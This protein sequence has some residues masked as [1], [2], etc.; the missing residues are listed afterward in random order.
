MWRLPQGV[1]SEVKACLS[2]LKKPAAGPRP[3]DAAATSPTVAKSLS[4]LAVTT[5][6]ATRW[7]V[8]TRFTRL[9]PDAY[10]FSQ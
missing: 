9:L 7:S 10:C 5:P 3:D 1:P 6:V 2:R 8:A 4:A